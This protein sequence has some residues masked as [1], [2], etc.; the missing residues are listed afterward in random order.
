MNL[1]CGRSLPYGKFILGGHDMP[2]ISNKTYKQK[3]IS[4]LDMYIVKFLE[5]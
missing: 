1:G 2:K 4:D 5:H 3:M